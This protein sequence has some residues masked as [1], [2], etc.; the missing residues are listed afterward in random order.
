MANLDS[1]KIKVY[2]TGYRGSNY[3][4]ESY[5][6]SETN[7]NS[8][9]SRLT[10]RPSYISKEVD[11][12]IQFVVDGYLFEC[13]KSDIIEKLNI[14]SP[15]DGTTIYAVI[16]TSEVE[17][18]NT[19]YK[20]LI[21]TNA[22]VPAILDSSGDEFLGVSFVTTV[23]SAEEG[24]TYV[25]N[26]LPL[27]RYSDSSSEWILISS[28]LLRFDTKQISN[29]GG[30]VTKNIS[31]EFSSDNIYAEKITSD[32]GG[33]DKTTIE[34]G[35][36]NTKEIVASTSIK[37][38]AIASTSANGAKVYADNTGKLLK[39]E[40][41]YDSGQSASFSFVSRVKQDSKGNVTV[42]KGSVPYAKV[43]VDTP[44]QCTPG[45][46]KME[47]SDSTGI[48]TIKLY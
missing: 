11:G 40:T 15:T 41:T 28:S 27:Y 19:K 48:L 10:Y 21:P 4:N 31:E 18:D 8:L 2:P 26:S 22:D 14:S 6:N 29:A 16:R 7:L 25:V 1:S 35:S 30:T 23:P 47:Y 39:D 37:D 42:E 44:A 9:S 36:I 5:V 43:V 17:V 3:N 38:T 32:A 46:V 13:D 12:H 20:T 33:N 45:V 24:A 34:H